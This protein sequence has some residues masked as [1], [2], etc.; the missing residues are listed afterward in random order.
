MA[1]Y[2]YST[3]CPYCTAME[4]QVL[5]DKEINAIMTQRL[6]SLRINVDKRADLAKKY[7][8]RGYPTTALLE[9]SGK[10]IVKVPGYMDKKT[11]KVF[12]EYARGKYYKTVGLREYFKK[13]GIEVD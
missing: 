3:Y 10:S 12:L 7:G 6:V 9:P 2:F 1:L 13:S 5:A 8:I 4:T 11:Y